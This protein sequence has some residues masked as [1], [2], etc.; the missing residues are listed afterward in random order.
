[1]SFLILAFAQTGLQIYIAI[2]IGAF[3]GFLSP[4]LQA[5]MTARTPAD[6]Q[7]ELQGAITSLYSLASIISPAAMAIIF[8]AY[9]DETGVYLPGAPFILAT[10]LA[11]LAMIVFAIGAK[12]LH[13]QPLPADQASEAIADSFD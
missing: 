1:V 10:G 8:T 3:A 12:R 9:T 13:D 4:A 2:A 6:S 11:V 7:G 5:L